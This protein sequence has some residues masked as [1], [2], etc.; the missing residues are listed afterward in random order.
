MTLPAPPSVYFAKCWKCQSLVKPLA[1]ATDVCMGPMTIRLGN[2]T[3]RSC[4]GL[5]SIDGLH[6][7]GSWAAC[8]RPRAFDPWSL[9]DIEVPI[10]WSRSATTLGGKRGRGHG[11]A[12]SKLSAR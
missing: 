7:A 10:Y 3:S 2:L 5:N 11:R 1:P 12:G 6:G 9:P 8:C 4:K